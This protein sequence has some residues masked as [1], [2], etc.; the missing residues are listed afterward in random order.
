MAR[1]TLVVEEKMV[2]GEVELSGEVSM[3]SLSQAT[4]SARTAAQREILM[5]FFMMFFS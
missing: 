2:A 5:I 4:A 3:Y 1:G